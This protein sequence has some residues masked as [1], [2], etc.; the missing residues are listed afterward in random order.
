MKPMAK[1]YFYYSTMNAGKSTMLLQA[2][3]NYQE[4]GMHTL[5]LAP[6]ID[7]RAG[8]K[9]ISSRIGLTAVAT[10]FDAT[11]NLFLQVQSLH[12][13]DRIDCVF[14]DEAQFLAEQQ[15]KQLSDIADDLG[16]PVLCYGLRTDFQGKLFTGSQ[17]LLAWADELIE[18]KTICHCGRKANMVLRIDASGQVVKAGAQ[19]K[20]GGNDNYVSVCRR[21]FKSGLI[22]RRRDE[23]MLDGFEE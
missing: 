9:T 12:E 5:L 7:D 11:D 13:R 23:L 1:I 10:P 21:H 8:E 19:I 17:Q 6:A 20:I 2:S 4:R 22:R 15:V 16:I 3:Y 18:I 14:V